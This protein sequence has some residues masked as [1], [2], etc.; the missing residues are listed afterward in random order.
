MSR[1]PQDVIRS[2]RADR[3]Q[4]GED[5]AVDA[6]PQ[7]DPAGLKFSEDLGGVVD[8]HDQD[9][10]DNAGWSSWSGGERIAALAMLVLLL[11]VLAAIVALVFW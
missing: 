10:I 9:L 5:L 1:R 6:P 11:V 7:R 2:T 4:R 8:P 3:R